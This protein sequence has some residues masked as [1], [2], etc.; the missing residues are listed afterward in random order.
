MTFATLCSF[1]V[2]FI[3][4]YCGEPL[5]RRLFALIQFVRLR[6]MNFNSELSLSQNVWSE[7]N[8][9]LGDS[10]STGSIWLRCD[11]QRRR[12]CFG[13]HL[14]ETVTKLFSSCV[15]RTLHLIDLCV[16][17]CPKQKV[18][19]VGDYFKFLFSSYYEISSHLAHRKGLQKKATFTI[20]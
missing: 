4:I 3:I 6:N 8:K 7:N 16:R 14:G 9:P 5:I 18:K 13:R 15:Q 17:H 1:L 2:P 11:L 10:P 12:W 19:M 20:L